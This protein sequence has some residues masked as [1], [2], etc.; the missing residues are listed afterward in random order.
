MA[1]PASIRA[2]REA[3]AEAADSRF[4]A[5]PF[6]GWNWRLEEAELLRQMDLFAEAGYGGFYIH[7][8]EGLETPFLGTVWFDRVR[9]VVKRA[10]E[11][12]LEVWI[13]DE[14]R[15][16]SG[17]AGGCVPSR[18]DEY[19]AKGLTIEVDA[20]ELPADAVAAY[21][22]QPES[23][24]SGDRI[25][26]FRRLGVGTPPPSGDEKLAVLRVEI[27]NRSDWFNGE[28]PPDNLNPDCVDA[29]IAAAYAPYEEAVGEY[30]G[31]TV[32]GFFYDEPGV[33][34][35]HVA[36]TKGRGWIPWTGGFPAFFA[37][38][39][40]W[41][42][43][44]SVPLV[45][46]DGDG[47]PAVRH[48]YWRTLAERFSET[49][50]ARIGAWCA[51]RGLQSSGHFLWE[52]DLGVSTRTSG[53]IMPNYRHQQLP[54]ID[55]L[56]ITD[57]ETSTV[58]QCASVVRQ[59]AKGGLVSE[60]YGCA[61]WDLDF[62]S[63]KWHGDWQAALG[64]TLRC[65]HHALETLKGCR[66]R[67]YPPSFGYQT[68]W[69][70]KLRDVEDYFA[71]INAV[72]EGT[73]PARD[74][75]VLHPATTAWTRAGSAPRG[76]SRRGADRDLPDLKEYGDTYNALLRGLSDA[77]LDCDVGDELIMEDSSA[78]APDGRLKVGDCAY[79][80]VVV[81]EA[82]SLLRS[83]FRLLKD[84]AAAGGVVAAVGKTPDLI[85]GRPSAELAAFFAGPEI[86]RVADAAA[87]VAALDTAPLGAALRILDLRQAD[88]SRARGI[89]SR[90]GDAADHS[91]LF[92]ANGDRMREVSFSVEVRRNGVLQEW[93]PRT[94]ERRPAE[95]VPAEG[96]CRF[97]VELGPNQS[98]LFLL[99]RS[100]ETAP[101]DA[102]ASA[103]APTQPRRAGFKAR[104]REQDAAAGARESTAALLDKPFRVES[105]LPNALPLDRAR[106]RVGDGPFSPELYVWDAQ[107]R[108]R[109]ELGL[110]PI[111]ANETRQRYL[112]ARDVHPRDGTSVAFVFGFEAEDNLE[113]PVSLAVE[114]LEDLAAVT[115]NGASVPLR[116]DG[117]YLDRALAT[118]PLPSPRRGSNE[119]EIEYRYRLG[120]EAEEVAIVGAFAVGA[121]RRLR[122]A[123]K[124]IALGDWGRLG[125]FH[126]PGSLVYHFAAEL[127]PR[128]G[129]RY[130]L[131]LGDRRA[132]TVAV[133]VNGKTAGTIPWRSSPRL[134]LAPLLAAGRND[135]GIEIVGSPRNFFG[136]FHSALSAD[137]KV[138]WMKF[139]STGTDRFD[140][141][142][143]VPY[144]LL[145][146][147][148]IIRM[149]G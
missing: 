135:V 28:A 58:K 87:L 99:D 110:P 147:S 90:L 128:A 134:D 62:E 102:L 27:A 118:I 63:Q 37:E 88:G 6:W 79:R 20:E 7:A 54:G 98:R 33:H 117:W 30:F 92:L 42:F 3:F 143:V 104:A 126:Y 16:P 40:G 32:K 64:V 96:G 100:G 49:F 51:A 14:D 129:E 91:V 85:E 109:G 142:A 103:D 34:D 123:E 47:S 111:W 73:D 52:G 74:L 4:R 76:F 82:D 26:S 38:R 31:A 72:Q 86:L 83:T 56:A 69:F 78:V 60:M 101:T 8:R 127:S 57:A 12:G 18:G 116:P 15:W 75:I 2:K 108:A 149:E 84:F 124:T 1:D 121:D 81:P 5:A 113:V 9:A 125:Y 23:D 95:A 66:K 130:E 50:S 97:A 36:M 71:R 68:P 35:R 107:E 93:D 146:P 89:R 106:F 148:R 112:W 22:Y 25:S 140:H 136:P 48:D 53:D 119:L 138:D 141:Y 105:T 55:I 41:D 10:A 46:F 77:Y 13:Y 29:F 17:F 43:L 24:G 120:T 59:F 139:R 80:A 145:G 137:G 67:D 44:D 122:R 144:G 131:E 114:A 11:L 39:R 61:G 65:Q 115:L 132:A 45:F 70:F 94:G 21:A 19:R 133:T